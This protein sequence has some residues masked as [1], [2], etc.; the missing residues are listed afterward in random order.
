[1]GWFSRKKNE[2]SIPA[3]ADWS[4]QVARDRGIPPTPASGKPAPRIRKSVIDLISAS[5]QSQHPNEFGA[6]LR[7]EKGIITELLLL[8]GTVSGRSHAIFFFNMLPIDFSVRGTVHS[9]PG[10]DPRPSDADL[11]LFRKHGSLHI[12]IAEPYTPRTWRA[13]DGRGDPI[14]L[15]VV[16]DIS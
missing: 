16:D 10:G 3:P 15:E 13:Y 11:E 5:A 9:H 4:A 8:P 7:S 1:V 14:R 12:I 6:M 2:P